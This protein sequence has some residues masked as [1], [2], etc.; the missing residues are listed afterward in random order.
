M[1]TKDFQPRAPSRQQVPKES[2]F[3][4]IMRGAR[5][6]RLP[7]SSGRCWKNLTSSRLMDKGWLGIGLDVLANS[8]LLFVVIYFIGVSLTYTVL[9]VIAVREILNQ[10]RHDRF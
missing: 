8:Y 4:R 3:S 2:R 9:L 10:L 5:R 6:V 1:G 7:T